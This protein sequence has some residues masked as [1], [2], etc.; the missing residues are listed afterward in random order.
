MI[1][2]VVGYTKKQN[3]NSDRN[4]SIDYS[5][6]TLSISNVNGL[7]IE[8]LISGKTN[9]KDNASGQN[10][11]FNSSESSISKVWDDQKDVLSNEIDEEIGQDGIYT[12]INI[13]PIKTTE[14]ILSTTT[15]FKE[16]IPALEQSLKSSG[17]YYCEKLLDSNTRTFAYVVAKNENYAQNLN[18]YFYYL[19]EENGSSSFISPFVLNISLL[20][21]E[22][23]RKTVL[24]SKTYAEIKHLAALKSSLV[25]A[26]GANYSDEVYKFIISEY[27]RTFDDRINGAPLQT[28]VFKLQLPNLEVIFHNSFITYVEFFILN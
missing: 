24:E 8:D 1:M 15:F 18:G 14:I 27:K 11:G 26:L 12:P 10:S 6:S 20:F 19:F 3:V 5:K 7:S 13:E 17:F 2:I 23:N 16:K 25:A 28:P 21:D 9:S 22:E 4:Q